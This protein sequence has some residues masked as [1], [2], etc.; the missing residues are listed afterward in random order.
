MEKGN[1]KLVNPYAAQTLRSTEDNRFVT[2][3]ENCGEYADAPVCENGE[4]DVQNPVCATTMDRYRGCPTNATDCANCATQVDNSD[5]RCCVGA[6]ES[7]G[8]NIDHFYC[9]ERDGGWGGIS[10][11]YLIIRDSNTPPLY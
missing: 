1:F 2:K 7:V 8:D 6:N 9:Y 11:C 10:W 4:Q 5:D 3:E